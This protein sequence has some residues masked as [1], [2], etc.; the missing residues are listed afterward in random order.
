M[1][2]AARIAILC[3]FV[4]SACVTGDPSSPS[5]ALSSAGGPDVTRQSTDRPARAR[6]D[7]SAAD[8]T[9][10]ARDPST[11]RLSF[12]RLASGLDSPVAV[13]FPQDG[14]GR[15]FIVEQ[16]GRIRIWTRRGGVRA[17]PYLGIAGRVQSGGEQ[18][19]LGLAFHPS[20]TRNR[21]FFVSYTDSQGDLRVVR[22]RGGETSASNNAL[23][24]THTVVLDI[25]HRLAGNHNGGQLNFGRSYLFVSTGDGGSGGDPQGNAQDKG[26]R[27]GKILRIDVDRRCGN[28]PYCSPSS[29]PF[30]GST[31]GHG[32]VFHLG[33]RNPWRWSFDRRTGAMWIADVGQ[34]DWE[35]ISVAGSRAKG[36]NFGWDCREG[37][38]DYESNAYCA[39]VDFKEPRHEY[40]NGVNGRCAIIGGY[41]YRGS[42][43]PELRGMYVYSDHCSREVWALGYHNGRWRNARVAT[44]PGNISAF[45][46]RPDGELVAVTLD[47][48][49]YRVGARVR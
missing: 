22:F 42:D 26:S 34:S 20:F 29:N 6:H 7:A 18:G 32:S 8:A 46:E 39:G 48:G 45:G 13:A 27:L 10:S 17:R 41:V 21:F 36:V 47:G 40:A 1:G 5:A 16:A 3:G 49:L 38:H 30:Y 33:L 11:I 4:A 24:R 12:R 31:P 28:R 19:M 25:P 37:A 23:E 44:A 14:S 2:T 35:E 43:D 15:A 9:A